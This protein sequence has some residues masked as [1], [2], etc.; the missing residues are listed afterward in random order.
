MGCDPIR[1]FRIVSEPTRVADAA[2][3][4]MFKRVHDSYD[5]NRVEAVNPQSVRES[6]NRFRIDWR[7]KPP[8]SDGFSGAFVLLLA[9]WKVAP[10]DDSVR[11]RV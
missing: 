7:L 4:R 6:E 11:P 10:T 3:E 2:N 8:R 1:L 5:L 9:V